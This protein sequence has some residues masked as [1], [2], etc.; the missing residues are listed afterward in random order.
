ML[1]GSTRLPTYELYGERRGESGEFWIHCETIAARSS[2]H[3]WE[4]GLHRHEVFQQ[5][6]YIRS[7]SG[8]AILERDI[9]PMTPPCVICVPPGLGHGFRFSRDIDGLVVTLVADRMPLVTGMARRPGDWLSAARLIPLSA[10]ADA[11]YLD[12]TLVRLY[13]E[14]SARRPGG[15]ALIEAYLKTVALMLNRLAGTG[16]TGLPMAAKLARIEALEALVANNYRNRWSVSD[17]ARA[18]N[19]TPT[20]L[21]RLTREATGMTVHDLV[22]ARVLE[23][24]RRNLVFTPATIRDVAEQLGFEDAAYF[25][26]CFRKRCGVTPRQFREEERRRLQDAMTAAEDA[27]LTRLALL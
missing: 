13:G 5:F 20:H 7:G 2:T 26:R 18:L 9:L 15:N 12:A 1:Q 14:L 6:L 27:A 3:Q 16:M 10:E 8:D 21:N 17:Y 25:V 24:A 11:A 4:I 23:E 22:M 19:L